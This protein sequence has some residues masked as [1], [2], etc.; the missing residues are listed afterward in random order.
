MFH[1]SGLA[2]LE[3]TNNSDRITPAVKKIEAELV[4]S[5]EEYLQRCSE[6]MDN[7][8]FKSHVQ[9][10]F[11]R[12]VS[13]DPPF[14]SQETSRI[15]IPCPRTG[16]KKAAEFPLGVGIPQKWRQMVVSA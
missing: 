16:L 4:S 3:P 8:L 9:N 2:L 6:F 13:F 14:R 11:K 7:V 5:R 10:Y 15:G 1:S 12:F